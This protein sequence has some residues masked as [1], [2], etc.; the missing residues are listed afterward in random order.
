MSDELR[1]QIYNNLIL[2]DTE[3]LLEIWQSANTD[4][5]SDDVFDILKD[6]LIERLG[7]VPPQPAEKQVPQILRKVEKHL[8]RNELDLAVSQ[9]E[10]AIQTDPNSAIAYNYLGEIHDQQ[11]Q[12]ELAIF[13]YQRAVQLDEEFKQAWENLFGVE[14]ELEDEF[15]RSS[16]KQHLDQALE[17]A[18]DDEPEKAREECE[19]ARSTLPGIAIAHNYLGMILQTLDQLEPAI[20]SY[21][22]AIQLNPRFYA[23]RENLANA[24]VRLEE[25]QYL[26][27]ANRP[28]EEIME[29]IETGKESNNNLVAEGEQ[30]GVPIPGWWYLDAN[31][32]LLKGWAGH[33]TRPGRSG[34]DPLDRDFEL[35][36]VEGVVIRRLLT[37]TFRTRNPFYLLVMTFLGIFYSWPFFC[38]P[39]IFIGDVNAIPMMIMGIPYLIIGIAF[40]VNVILSLQL[41]S[42]GEYNDEESTFF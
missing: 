30:D 35:A 1:T 23:A 36:H 41:I 34:Y 14:A 12:L 5:W 15:E 3:D 21:L 32:F 24:R 42:S 8:D 10:L 16:A 37:R 18:Y 26:R 27:A 40:L 31:A 29:A 20:A 2:R 7:Y 11:G 28:L 19:L 38:F 39:V 33:R 6:I 22:K 9:C 4:E 17:Y 25:E 13:N